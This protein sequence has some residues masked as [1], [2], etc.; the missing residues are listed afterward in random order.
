MST[1]SEVVTSGEH[2]IDDAA[3]AARKFAVTAYMLFRS[4]DSTIR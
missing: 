3:P 2:L 4:G 1:A